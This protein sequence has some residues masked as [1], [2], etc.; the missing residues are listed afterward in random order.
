MK[1]QNARN[2]SCE[3]S[4]DKQ[5]KSHLSIENQQAECQRYFDIYLSP[6][7]AAWGGLFGD[8]EGIS[9]KVPTLRRPAAIELDRRLRAGDHVISLAVDR[10][11]RD[12]ADLVAVTDRW[13]KM[14]V[15]IH[16]IQERLIMD[17]TPSALF[18]L[19]LCTAF[20]QWDRSKIS[21]RVKD[22]NAA[23]RARGDKTVGNKPAY[24]K[25]RSRTK[26]E[27][28]DS[29]REI[30]ALQLLLHLRDVQQMT[31]EQIALLA[32]R[33]ITLR[34]CTFS[35][36]WR[37]KQIIDRARE[38]G[39]QPSLRYWSM[40]ES[41]KRRCVPQAQIEM[42]MAAGVEIPWGKVA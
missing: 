38:A 25:Q 2:A 28:V 29:D 5:F 41:K 30:A 13:M 15:T 6:K 37:T 23:R 42:A 22:A 16:F 26:L 1:I 34:S 35:G 40:V 33:A 7:G 20:A 17:G 11:W 10:L 32:G 36:T 24:G 4:S 8:D 9:S 12:M 3:F 18:Q 27:W 14:G 31:F 19:H 21:Q 39:H